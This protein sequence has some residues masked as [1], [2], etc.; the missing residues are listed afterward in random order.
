MDDRED[1]DFLQQFMARAKKREA[2]LASIGEVSDTTT[3]ETGEEFSYPPLS[4]LP[5]EGGEATP[6]PNETTRQDESSN[7]DYRRE[8]TSPASVSDLNY[9]SDLSLDCDTINTNTTNE[10]YRAEPVVCHSS[11][12]QQ[13]S[14][15]QYLP[16][17]QAS[18]RKTA[19]SF[20]AL[21]H[22]YHQE[23]PVPLQERQQEQ[24]ATSSHSLPSSLTDEQ[25]IK[26]LKRKIER[27]E[28]AKSQLKKAVEISK[29]GS[30]EHIEAA[31]LLQITDHEH[32]AYTNHVAMLE[33]GVRKKAESL[34]SLKL[35]G[36][37]LRISS[38]LR[39]DL[40]EDGVS[41]YFFCVASCGIDVKA[42][43]VVDTDDIRK[44]DLKAYLQFKE[45][46]SFADLPP[47]FVV[48]LEVF[49]LV[50]GQQFPK[51]L[52]RLTPSKKSKITPDT[53]FKRV[54]SL[55]LTL[56]DRDVSYKN[57]MQ[58][59]KHE[60]SKYIE[61][62]CKFQMEL[63][64]EQLPTKA[65]MLHVR[66]LDGGGRPDWARF[67][68]ELSGGQVRFWK[69][70]Q[71]ALDG[72]KPNQILEIKEICSES[73]Q[74]LTPDDDL[75]RQNS[76]VIYTFQ[77]VFGGEGDTLFQ[78]ILR[79]DCKFKVVKHQLAAENKED[80][81][82]WCTLLDKSMHC[83]REWHGKAKI[84]SIEEAKEIFSASY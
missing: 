70:K 8:N 44:Q 31:K 83:F 18:P 57:L 48:K 66:C 76:F 30:K 55:R 39:N 36:I 65:G 74:K 43:E 53:N 42:T 46:L 84:Y 34:G 28:Q 12:E 63:R 4:P 49:E 15:N 35:S 27:V 26:D 3:S 81:D 22:H 24:K 5:E 11:P 75:Y 37:R 47:D 60:E 19:P 73:V 1:D 41:H 71:D 56:A 16:T 82:A 62:E 17:R 79:E 80:R 21:H 32:L 51:L 78:R 25:V 45:R 50:I 7:T 10:V 52:S 38:K 64:P 54:G 61:K 23:Q 67:W 40:A 6:S 14:T 33:K 13:L 68:V 72:K 59:S 2:K 58:W 77:Q 69:S 9:S 29:H 20:E